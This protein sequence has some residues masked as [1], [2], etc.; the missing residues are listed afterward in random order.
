[1][2]VPDSPGDQSRTKVTFQIDTEARDRAALDD[3]VPLF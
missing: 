3:D 1:M 2:A